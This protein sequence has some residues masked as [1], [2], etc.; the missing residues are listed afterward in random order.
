MVVLIR[1]FAF[2][3]FL[4]IFS[5]QVPA[6]AVV[7]LDDDFTNT[8][9]VD[10]NQTTAYVNTSNGGYVRLKK[11]PKPNA[12][13]IN[14]FGEYAVPTTDGGIK[15]FTYDESTGTSRQDASMSIPGVT[16]A[17][18]VAMPSEGAVLWAYRSGSGIY[19]YEYNDSAGSMSEIHKV[20]GI[21]G[22]LSVTAFPAANDGAGALR[23]SGTGTGIIDIYQVTAENNLVVAMSFDTGITNPK[24]I[25]FV[26]GTGEY[27]DVLYATPNT[28]YFFVNDES[29]GSYR[30][31][32]SRRTNLVNA[33]AVSTSSSRHGAAVLTPI[34]ADHYA[35]TEGAPQ[36]VSVLS[37]GS[38]N[39]AIAI[40]LNPDG[41]DQAII[42]EGGDVQYWR[43]DEET[44]AMRRDASMEQ[45]G[46]NLSG[47][48]HH[49]EEYLST[50]IDGGSSYDEIRITAQTNLPAGTSVTYYI[51]SDSGGSF[52]AVSSG[53][54]TPVTAGRYFVVRA[55]LDT[56]D[57]SV[58][59][60]ILRV[61][62]EVSALS[63]NNLRVLAIADNVSGQVLPTS[64]FPVLAK[65][66]AEMLFE[67]TTTGSA[68]QVWA[69]FSNGVQVALIPLSPTTNENNAW[70]GTFTVPLDSV[71]GSMIGVTLTAQ[72][73][74]NQ[75]H[76]VQSPFILI[77][78]QVLYD[79]DLKLT[80]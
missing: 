30:E 73:G 69:D 49:P 65:I 43:Y 18:E 67:A 63:I 60:Q 21:T 1:L 64:T 26:P 20:L 46:L 52:T 71:D 66:G 34:L 45:T 48:Y 25:S 27:P 7:I 12:V 24:S 29:I 56:T 10:I 72:K 3:L 19:R 74:T 47:G 15:F 5:I 78:G 9:Y 16:D 51:S 57:I 44:G 70:R 13:A 36:Q 8:T 38:L 41:Y 32:T 77:N 54:W 50:V 79:V 22:V 59:P 4:S 58:T 14:R 31:D 42:T 62:L 28:L 37:A 61:T 11:Q 23:T 33:G 55:V 76:L 53:V 35:Y 40:S 80:Q 6:C 17:E 39:G 68:E 2:I 75:K